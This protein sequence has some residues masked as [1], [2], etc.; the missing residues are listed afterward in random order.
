[1]E[2]C[3]LSVGRR[4]RFYLAQYVCRMQTVCAV[5]HHNRLDAPGS[6][7]KLK[8]YATTKR[9]VHARRERDHSREVRLATPILRGAS[10]ALLIFLVPFLF[11]SHCICITAIHDLARRRWIRAEA[12]RYGHAVRAVLCATFPVA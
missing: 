3:R 5:C 11:M 1:M 6:C 9:A 2:R 8:Q 4:D 7:M 12:L 10:P